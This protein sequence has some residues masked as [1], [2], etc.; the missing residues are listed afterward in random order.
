MRHLSISNKE[1]EIQNSDW[2]RLRGKDGTLGGSS[3]RYVSEAWR[4][5]GEVERRGDMC[6][7]VRDGGMAPRTGHR[8][9]QVSGLV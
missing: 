9:K 3:M 4:Q 7:C 2:G 1:L 6:V 5:R 8:G